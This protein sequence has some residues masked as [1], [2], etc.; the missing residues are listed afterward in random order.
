MSALTTEQALGKTQPEHSF[1]VRM[2]GVGRQSGT[3]DA[4]DHDFFEASLPHPMQAVFNANPQRTFRIFADRIDVLRCKT[5]RR[6]VRRELSVYEAAQPSAP[7][8]NPDRPVFALV[9]R[10]SVAGAQTLSLGVNLYDLPAKP[11]QAGGG[12]R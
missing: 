4:F 8:S 1:P 3:A 11:V 9:H 2:N 5:I 12:G 7:G 6:S 10:V